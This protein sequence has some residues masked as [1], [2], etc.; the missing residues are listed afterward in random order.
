MPPWPSN[1]LTELFDIDLPI[2]LAPM[3]GCGGVD[4][5]VA[6][7]DAGGLGAYPCAYVAPEKIE[8]DVAAIRT[9]TSRPLNLNFFCHE[10]P[11]FETNRQEVWRSALEPYYAEFGADLPSPLSAAPPSSFNA[12]L[13]ASVEK[14]R[15]N[16]VSF[17]F[18]LPHVQEQQ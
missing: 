16:V 14:L 10:E 8:A 2:L 13:C 9:S 18:G 12:D 3:A 4:L 15:P 7:A 5:A 17:H 11:V 1:R 6:V